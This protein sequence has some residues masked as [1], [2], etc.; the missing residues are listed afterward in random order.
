MLSWSVSLRK[1][2]RSIVL[3]SWTM[4]KPAVMD[5]FDRQRFCTNRYKQQLA[6][7][8]GCRRSVSNGLYNACASSYRLKNSLRVL[9][10]MNTNFTCSV[11]LPSL[12]QVGVI[13]RIFGSLLRDPYT[14]L[15]GVF[16][17]VDN[18]DSGGVLI[19]LKDL[20]VH[21]CPTPMNPN[22]F[23]NSYLFS[24]YFILAFTTVWRSM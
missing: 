22:S 16:L 9:K 10:S 4:S 1:S 21:N 20:E 15:V 8:I 19:D 12:K 2:R 13:E 3:R 14:E 24:F 23:R 6:A 5:V 7:R 18:C 17:V 11:L